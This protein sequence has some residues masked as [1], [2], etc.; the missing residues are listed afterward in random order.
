VIAAKRRRFE[1]ADLPII[2]VDGKKRELVG[3]FKNAGRTWRRRERSVND[4]DFPSDAVGVALPYG[5]YDERRNAAT[6]VVGTS[7]ETAEFAVDA[8][9]AWWR[10]E[11][12][13]R[14]P[15]AKKLLILADSGGA[16]SPRC[17]IWKCDLQS[18]L[19]NA[20]R[21]TVTVCHYPPGAS[22]WNPIEHRVFSQISRNWQGVP[23]ETYE[24][25]TRYISATTTQT[26]LAVS[27]ILNKKAYETGKEVS[28]RELELLNIRSPKDLPDWNYT[29]SP[30]T[31]KQLAKM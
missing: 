9:E 31:A 18:K 5:I 29:I 22:K 1:T 28:D 17:K 27:A 8:I 20:H 24:V 4:H 19:C 2:S 21:L 13:E 12:R 3:N 14:Y 30:Y 25:I 26:G 7:K 23:L 10:R 6:I 11:G 16:N 15:D